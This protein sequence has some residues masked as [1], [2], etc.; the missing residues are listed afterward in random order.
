MVKLR[1]S[2]TYNRDWEDL[3]VESPDLEKEIEKN[4]S[5]FKHNPNDTRLDNHSLTKRMKGKWAFS[6][7]DNIRIVYLWLGRAT[8]SFL[9]IGPHEEV[10]VK[11]KK[12]SPK[13]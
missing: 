11:T 5:R 7:M 13:R 3:L 4:V 2:G 9:E 6:I 8:V 12:Q 10:Y 1:K